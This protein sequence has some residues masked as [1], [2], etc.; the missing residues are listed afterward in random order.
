MNLIYDLIMS[1]S[2][3]NSPVRDVRV[4]VSWTGVWGKYCGLSKTYGIPVVHGN[5]TRDMGRLTEKTTLELVE[6]LKSWNLVE[7]S[8]GMAAL[9]SMIKAEGAI[10]LNAKE[11][12]LSKGTG[13]R[14]VMA[15]AFPFT[16]ELK[17]LAKELWVLELD[18]NY[19]DPA[20][21][22]I[23]ETAA[24]YLIPQSDMVVITGSTL[25]NKSLERLMEL[26]RTAGAYTVILGPSTP[27]SPVLFD[28]GA[29]LIGGAEV[30]QPEPVLRKLSQ[31]GGMLD[32]KVCPG[33]I[34]F[35][36]LQR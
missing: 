6:Y 4:G 21:G 24:E 13:K 10:D 17:K 29:H 23:V 14:V 12:I 30:T 20:H 3:N 11:I 35:K 18:K 19:V 25:I 22:I 28:Y 2:Q 1:V 7:A 16:P 15:G 5:Y 32:S 33:E 36:V 9:N 27:L 34:V 26:A 31:S 8:I